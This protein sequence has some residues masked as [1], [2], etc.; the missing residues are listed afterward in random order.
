[1]PCRERGLALVSVLQLLA[2][3]LVIGLMLGEK[4]LR[5]TR[6]EILAGVR[7][8]ALQAAGTGI[9]SARHRLATTY[10]ASSGWALHLAGNP[11]GERY[12]ESPVFTLTVGDVPVDIFLRDNPDGDADPRRDS[13]LKLMVLARARPRGGAAVMVETLCGFDAATAAG[14]RQSGGDA[15]RSGGAD[16]DG[17][18]APWSAPV[19][20]FHLHD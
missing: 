17:V 12:P 3:L 10:A 20:T 15:G 13:D 5:A 9:E 2:L 18:A 16:A 11:D 1:M 6:G 4:V 19:D 14:Y 7:E 8:Q